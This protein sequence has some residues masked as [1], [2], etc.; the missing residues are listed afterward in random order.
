MSE[1]LGCGGQTGEMQM[2][3]IEAVLI[4]IWRTLPKNSNGRLERRSLRYIAYRY[5]NQKSS[6]LLRGFQPSHPVNQSTWGNEDILSKRV[7]AY[8]ASVLE[9]QHAL[10]HGFDLRDAT[11]MVATLE[12]LIFDSESTILETVYA[13]QHKPTTRSLSEA[14]LG[15]VLHDYMVHWI[16]GDYDEGIRLVLNNKSLIY[17]SIPHWDEIV[18]MAQGQIKTL[19]FQRQNSPALVSRSGHNALAARYSFE[20]AHQV[21]G[22]IRSSFASFWDSECA[23]MKA[24]LV[25]MDPLNTGRVPLSQFY[26]TGLDA[27][28]RFGESEAYLRDLGVLDETSSWRGKQVIIPNYI[29]GASNCIIGAKHYLVC[30]M[31]E[32]HSILGEIEAAIGAPLALVSELLPIVRNMTSQTTV[33]HDDPPQLAGALSDQLDQIAAMHGGKVPIHGRLFAQ[34]LH[35]AFPHE[36][37]FPHKA[38]V[39]VSKTPD[40]Y[41]DD[42]I[43]TTAEMKKHASTKLDALNVSE[44][45]MEQLEWMSQWSSEEELIADYT[46]LKGTVLSKHVFIS[47]G[48]FLL[49]VLPLLGMVKAKSGTLGSDQGFP[50]TDGKSHFV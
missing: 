23:A 33:D 3:A 14:G 7:P 36:C 47:W 32:C 12:Q 15:Q 50:L 30:C 9:S 43:A 48:I 16:L 21:I 18:G 17:E 19:N 42:F 8:V 37:A 1:A 6:L 41:G 31:N 4:P 20:D 44:V 49:V 11:Q 28:W 45:G 22:G 2:K 25:E 24:S 26:G 35:Y 40:Q 39:A 5:F 34:W 29:Q 13:S 46:E 38:G 10:L 27:D